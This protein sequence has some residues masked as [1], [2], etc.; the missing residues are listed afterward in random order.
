MVG[1]VPAD[2]R[3]GGAAEMVFRNL[4]DAVFEFM[5]RDASANSLKG[6]LGLCE[7]LLTRMLKD[8][9]RI[10]D[11]TEVDRKIITI[12]SGDII[13]SIKQIG[14][15]FSES[16]K[17]DMEGQFDSLLTLSCDL[18]KVVNSEQYSESS[19]D[20]LLGRYYWNDEFLSR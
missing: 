20:E 5:Y 17:H 12:L 6:Q 19:L 13:A 11:I 1:S 8:L 18:H 9:E 15:M 4:D 10:D 16:D 14:T 3:I 2:W 7:V